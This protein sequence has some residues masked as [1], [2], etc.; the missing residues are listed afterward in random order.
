MWNDRRFSLIAVSKTNTDT[1][2]IPL[3]ELQVHLYI[4]LQELTGQITLGL[5][6][7]VWSAACSQQ[8]TDP[9]DN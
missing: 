9:K 6:T 4:I 3:F 8:T 1:V 7:Y 2:C 5:I